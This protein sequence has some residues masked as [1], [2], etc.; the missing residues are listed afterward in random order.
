MCTKDENVNVI[1]T[2]Q[3]VG[4]HTF[5]RL[6]SGIRH[7]GKEPNV[8]FNN[9]VQRIFWS[10]FTYWNDQSTATGTLRTL[11]LIHEVI[12]VCFL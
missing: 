4:K 1:H 12:H 8:A 2:L 5:F 7:G 6:L 3:R 9:I 10:E 11:L